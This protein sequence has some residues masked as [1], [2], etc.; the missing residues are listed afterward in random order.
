ML[1]I[2]LT[3]ATIAGYCAIST[4]QTTFSKRFDWPGGL[5]EVYSKT[6][7]TPAVNGQVWLTGSDQEW[8]GVGRR[9]HVFKFTPNGELVEGRRLVSADGKSYFINGFRESSEGDKYLSIIY[10]N[11]PIA[12]S[13]LTPQMYICKFDVAWNYIWAK[14]I[15]VPNGLLNFTSNVFDFNENQNSVVC[16]VNALDN[17]LFCINSNGTL[18]W[19]R[20][21][22]TGAVANGTS[23][24]IAEQLTVDHINGGILYMFYDNDD[25]ETQFVIL[26]P[27]T[28]DIIEAKGL[29]KQFPYDVQVLPN[30]NIV[31]LTRDGFTD[32]NVRVT[33]FDIYLNPINSWEVNGYTISSGASVLPGLNN[34]LFIQ[35]EGVFDSGILLFKLNTDG[36][37]LD[38]RKY[39]GLKQENGRARPYFLPDY[40]SFWITGIP[41]SA[42]IGTAALVSFDSDLK[43]NNCIGATMCPTIAFSSI[44][45]RDI[46]PSFGPVIM[47]NNPLDLNWQFVSV[48]PVDF[49][50]EPPNGS[51]EL[52]AFFVTPDTICAGSTIE[53]DSLANASANSVLWLLPGTDLNNSIIKNPSPVR[54]NQVGT[55]TITQIAS[56]E[57]GSDTFSRSIVVLPNPTVSLPADQIVCNQPTL[58]LLAQI[59]NATSWTWSN[60]STS[61]TPTVNTDGT[62][63]V[64]VTNGAGCTATDDIAVRFVASEAEFEAPE[65]ICTGQEFTLA[66]SNVASGATYR[67]TSIPAAAGWP[68]IGQTVT[69]TWS[70]PGTY[71]VVLDVEISTC[72]RSASATVEVLQSPAVD[73]GPDLR[74]ADDRT[75]TLRPVLTP[76]DADFDWNDQVPDLIRRIEAAG[77]YI[78]EATVGNCIDSDTVLIYP[79]LRV[80]RP[81]AIAPESLDNQLFT[82]AINESGATLISLEIYDRWGSLVFQGRE[83][84]VWDGT[85]NGQV[86]DAGVYIYLARVRLDE[87]I[88]VRYS[89][90]IH[91]V[92]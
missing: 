64:T 14:E 69:A 79:P 56:S 41:K 44:G 33:I 23:Y 46:V 11:S 47:L 80:Y 30:G 35:G 39:T 27:T 91:V 43:T 3:F 12:N 40:S 42:D 34:T 8:E 76:P 67:W 53:V 89:G 16:S 62:Y 82:L 66:A 45:V 28:G 5:E 73:L 78:L 29:L 90:D 19:S 15:V 57:C 58:T 50:E 88:E 74:L 10:E 18:M 72:S 48:N 81:N 70:T 86:A 60:G 75:T 36:Q 87:G 22:D 59:N 24:F 1:R 84:A 83:N 38:S 20:R 61:L 85:I 2:L 32:Y 9:G 51:V 21:F 92:R 77:T 26:N 7:L 6:S 4:A 25:D 13:L 68:L 54:Y 55:F 49:C 17:Y 37:L 71:E 63:T 52:S 65:R 31:T